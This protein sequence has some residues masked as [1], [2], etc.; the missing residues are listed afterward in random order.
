[1]VVDHVV[2]EIEDRGGV[3]VFGSHPRMAVVVVGE[4][5]VSPSPGRGSSMAP[6]FETNT[7]AIANGRMRV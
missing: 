4:Q 5:A 2:A 1:M 3:A 6:A 7:A